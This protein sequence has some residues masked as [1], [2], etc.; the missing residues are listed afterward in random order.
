ME[1]DSLT[2]PAPPIVSV[3]TDQHAQNMWVLGRMHGHLESLDRRMGEIVEQNRVRNGR[4][5]KSEE[6]IQRIDRQIAT[7][8]GTRAG[9]RLSWSVVTFLVGVAVTILGI[10]ATVLVKTWR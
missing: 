8:E 5:E 2:P 1:T 4:I 9:I 10:V 6:E 7:S 3:P